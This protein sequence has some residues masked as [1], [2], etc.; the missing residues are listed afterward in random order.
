ML[1]ILILF[2]GGEVLFDLYLPDKIQEIISLFAKGKP[3][4]K[5]I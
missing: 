1:S 4:A 2:I 5:E 3:T